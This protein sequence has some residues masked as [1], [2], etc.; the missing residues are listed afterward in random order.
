[1]VIKAADAARTLAALPE[2]ESKIATICPDCRAKNLREALVYEAV[3]GDRVR[4]AVQYAAEWRQ[5]F[6]VKVSPDGDVYCSFGYG[7]FLESAATGSTVSREGR[8]EVK[9]GEGEQEVTGPLRGGRVSF[10]ASGQIDL[11]DQQI[12]GTPLRERTQQELLCTLVFEHPSSFPPIGPV[13][14]RDIL[15]LLQVVEDRALV[16]AVHLTPPGAPVRLETGIRELGE[17]RRHILITYKDLK[18]PDVD[19][20]TVQV[21]LGLGPRAEAWPPKSYV[22]AASRAERT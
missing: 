11:G 3:A 9:Y 4:L 22:L 15:V 19:H 18:V 2:G 12:F 14:D 5:I 8:L 7:E 20:V 17:P 21:V 13:G 10:H 6:W 1:M 16:G